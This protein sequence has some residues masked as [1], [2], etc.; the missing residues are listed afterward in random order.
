[1][2]RFKAD[3]NRFCLKAEQVWAKAVQD[4]IWGVRDLNISREYLNMLKT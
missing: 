1:M 4:L 2:N 3:M